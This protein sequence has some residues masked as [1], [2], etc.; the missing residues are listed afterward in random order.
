[1]NPNQERKNPMDP[2][3]DNTKSCEEDNQP[4]RFAG[5]ELGAQ[6]RFEAR[7][8]FFIARESVVRSESRKRCLPIL[9]KP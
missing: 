9:L 8:L 6:R 1:M 3:K 4:I 7:N 5:S 2:T